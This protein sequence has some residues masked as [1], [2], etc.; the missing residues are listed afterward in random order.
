[1]Y[2]AVHALGLPTIRLRSSAQAAEALPWILRGDPGGYQHDIVPWSKP[3][4]LP[5]QIEPR[6]GA[7]F[8][9]SE[10]LRDERGSEYLQSK[11]YSQFL[12]FL[13]HTLKPPHRQ[14]VEDVFKLL[15]KKHVKPFEYHQVNTAG[16]DW[17]T[18]LD[19]ALKDTTHFVVLLSD[20]YEQ[21]EVCTQEMDTILA[22]GNAVTILPF[23]LGGR[24]RPN[25]KLAGRHNQLLPADTG[26]AARAIV[27]RT[28][29]SLEDALKEAEKQ[30][31]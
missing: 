30:A 28:M 22:R 15:E 10:A 11:R 2:A 31:R 17:K 13:S 1:L 24:S 25:P 18:A 3:E 21:S 6:I 29:A 9:L 14:L 26:E 5:E 19:Q 23:L 20:D 8:H 4:D 12:V 7:M 16:I 27:E